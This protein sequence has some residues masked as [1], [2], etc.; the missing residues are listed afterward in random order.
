M[1][2]YPA[3]LLRLDIDDLV[4]RPGFDEILASPLFADRVKPR[5]ELAIAGLRDNTHVSGC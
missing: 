1:L 3:A 2:H 5:I 4:P